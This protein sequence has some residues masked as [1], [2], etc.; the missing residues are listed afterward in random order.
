MPKF[1]PHLERPSALAASPSGRAFVLGGAREGR[2]GSS[3]HLLPLP[4][5][6]PPGL[7]AVEGATTAA[8][9]LGAELIVI[10]T[11][12]GKILGFEASGEALRRLFELPAHQ[13]PV[14]ALVADVLGKTLVSV[15][16]DGALKTWSSTGTELKASGTAAISERPLRAVALDPSG[17]SL[18]AGGDDGVLRLL[19]IAEL[20]KA[21]RATP[22][23]GGAISALAFLGDGRVAA[24][25]ADGAIRFAF[26]EGQS[27]V[28]DRA[29]EHAHI[30][31][32]R[33]LV[34][35]PVIFGDADQELPRKLFS[36]GEDG[37]LKAWPIENR[38]RPKALELG[39]GALTALTHVPAKERAKPEDRGGQLIA[40]G[41]GRW[42]ALSAL[43]SDGELT[44][45][46]EKIGS[47]LDRL[48]EALDHQ[49]PAP[50]Q[51]AI[52]ALGA[53][54]EDAAREL[55]E[56]PLA[57]D[58]KPE[59]KVLAAKLLGQGA[60]RRAR[61]ALR[62]A[63]SDAHPDVRRAAFDALGTIEAD[64][65]LA[66][67]RAGLASSAE[68]LRLLAVERLPALRQRSPLVPGLIAERLSDG[69]A[70][71]R[72]K[73]LDALFGLEP[74]GALE[75]VR[76]TMKRGAPDVRAEA[77]IRLGTS[78][79]AEAGEARLI[80]E[81]ALDDADPA[82]RGMA[83]LI[84][85]G[86]VPRLKD[87]LS[88]VDPLTKDAL[89]KLQ[90][91][92]PLSRTPASGPLQEADK[93]TL[94]AAMASQRPDTALRGARCLALLGD[95][96]ST[97]ALLQ[98]SREPSAEI[99]RYVVEALLSTLRATP[100]D[101]RA[102]ARLEWLLDDAEAVVRSAAFDALK[103]LAAA[104]AEPA[105]S[106]LDLA[107]IALRSAFEDV[108]VRALQILVAVGADSPARKRADRLV[109]DALDDEA[110]KVRNEAFKTLWA[111]HARQPK[112]ALELGARS[113][114]ADVRR[115]VISELERQKGDFV[116]PLL[117]ELVQD[118]VSEVGL[119]AYD[120]LTKADA[121]K[122]RGDVHLR[123]MGSPRFEVRAKGAA[124]AAFAPADEMKSRL[125]QL[126]EDDHP[127]VHLAAIE[128]LDKLAGYDEVAFAFAF[129][130]V[131]YEL[132]VR[133][134]ELAGTRRDKRCVDPLKSF[135][136]IPKTHVSRP[137]EDLRA[138]AA[139]AL[140]DVGDP[141]IV[142]FYVS[143]LDDENPLV[144]EMGARGLATACR[145]GAEGPLIAALGH[146]ELPVRSWAA[147]GLA[148][149]GDP[150]ALPVLAGTIRHEHR[151]IRAGAVLGF[152]ALGA[153]GVQ[154]ILQALSDPDR[155]VQDLV[156]AVI[157]AR[158]V[159]LA[160]A[161]L[162]PDLLVSAL[163]SSHP[164]VRFGAA[165]ALEARAAKEP[166]ERWALGLVG[167][168]RPERADEMKS[169]PPEAKQAALL[170]VLVS[171]LASDDPEQR[172][173]A[174]QVLSL[175]PQPEAFWREAQRLEKPTAAGR[176]W[177]PH[178]NFAA[179]KRETRKKDWIRRLFG[180]GEA[181]KAASASADTARV[182]T[183][184][185]LTGGRGGGAVPPLTGGAP[186][187]ELVFGAYA[188]LVRQAPPKGDADET[189][190]VR[191][192]ALERLTVLA[193]MPAIGRDA[194]LPIARR[195]LS[196]PHY[197]V[198]RSA[199]T[200]LRTLITD[201]PLTPEV[202]ALASDAADVGQKAVDALVALAQAGN[203]EA[204]A[205]VIGALS[206]R[207][208]DVRS[209]ALQRLVRLFPTGS[210]EPWLIALG[211]PEPDVRQAV[212]DRVL[213]A[214]DPRIFEA[215][216]RALESDDADLR[217]KAAIALA[218]RGDVRTADVLAGFLRTDKLQDA[219][220]ALVSLSAAE[221]K[222]SGRP[223]QPWEGSAR[224]ARAVAERLSNDP[225]RS[226]PRRT[227]I[228]ALATIGDPAGDRVLLDF[229]SAAPED[230]PDARY[231]ALMALFAIARHK[232]EPERRLKDGSTRP[233]YEEAQL[234]S[235]VEEAVRS[236][237]TGLRLECAKVLGSVADGGAERALAALAADRDPTVRVAAAE[238]LAFRA[239][240]FEAATLD[241]LAALL[242]Q[243]RR[244]LVLP[245]AEGLAA[246]RRPEAFQ[247]LLLV[248]K[249]GEPPERLRAALALGSLGDRRAI[250]HLIGYVEP[251]EELEEAELPLVPAAAE[252]LGRM[253]ARLS[254]EEE[255]RVRTLV[256][257]LA[258]E[259]GPTVNLP[260]I[261]G[262]R[263]AGDD[264]S[265][266][267]VE[268]IAADRVEQSAV[269][270]YAA[271]ELGRFPKPATSEG[272]LAGL[273]KDEDKNVRAAALEA[274]L[275]AFPAE[276]T[277]VELHALSSPYVDVS[278]TA[279][280]FLATRGDPV[281]L[282]GRLAEIRDPEV[283]R[284][285]RHGLVRRK[286]APS[287]ELKNLFEAKLAGVR[288][289]AAHLA[290]A[291]R[292][293][294]LGPTVL[295]ALSK[296]RGIYAERSARTLPGSRTSEHQELA[297]VAQ[298]WSLELWAAGQLG[299]DAKAETLP[300]VDARKAPAAVRQAA[301]YLLAETPEAVDL[302]ALRAALGDSSPLVRRAAGAVLAKLPAAKSAE[303]LRSEQSPDPSAIRRAVLSLDPATAAGFSAT[304]G[305]FPAVLS[306]L[307]GGQ[308]AAALLAIA[309]D[310]KLEASPERLAAIAALGL[311]GGEEVKAALLALYNGAG[312]DAVKRAAFRALR[313]LARAA[314]PRFK[315]GED[316]ERGK[317]GASSGGGGDEDED[318]GDE[319]DDDGGDDDEDEDEDDDE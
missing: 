98:L 126:V 68:D 240:N 99:R 75:P 239:E 230:A 204:K 220:D 96:R 34:M 134:G 120:K 285:L 77:L 9:F 206:A 33:A 123:A 101:D 308:R 313:R 132:R 107:E 253:L 30:G 13:G 118:A 67:A 97:G 241:P 138:R 245:A 170:Q 129:S 284:R 110:P 171:A 290:G 228:E 234:L 162:P 211:S 57:R 61:A 218:R 256:V 310:Q 266:T 272:V 115:G 164:E 297:D 130:S 198:R 64:D 161:G 24:G 127:S 274:L 231:P 232:S 294:A 141:A 117:L 283:R 108:R 29:G 16:A 91:R 279:A 41:R 205:R 201:D 215:L 226:A 52:E 208:A 287:A 219:L 43:S 221:A 144:R 153:D 31:P 59:L 90:T 267:V 159:A 295:A 122:K 224:A 249:A 238:S 255:K 54:T 80:V 260:A 11:D 56:L 185:R 114:H 214:E 248:L 111:W 92:G 309:N 149:L 156:F 207:S 263:H 244:E 163:S 282:A 178:T 157:V 213:D 4:K 46:F 318:D 286:A 165:R 301:L 32:I 152:V 183:V 189:H 292:D 116:R 81:A 47:E 222:K 147:E 186:L 26:T 106:D 143:L 168:R 160:K 193:S 42:L 137:S 142:P 136:S 76:L 269:R 216:G 195:A 48:R 289:D 176:P 22:L 88:K 121:D 268:N 5:L 145:L 17:A 250:E 200:A 71:V 262:L 312:P 94:F 188:G 300:L 50:R 317:S 38:R 2:P 247:A 1:A 44:D 131:F 223:F 257:R 319:D 40:S 166:A 273:L 39:L 179:E 60:R 173:T 277:R 25:S 133:A 20:S 225:D 199:V 84:G 175:R 275:R 306:G 258:T 82:V 235:Y 3:I 105:T 85:V 237:D 112:T 311:I 264:Q 298:A 139:R 104:A 15:G 109:G 93:E 243:G 102:R 242:R 303:I 18:A 74:A 316:Q 100:S 184:I 72:V 23:E 181:T 89:D 251:T 192:D 128:A 202:L 246:R 148:R 291:A 271:R 314:T 51:A 172:Y 197:L 236:T 37:I 58:K 124:G 288:L 304:K 212:V 167:P 307:L 252:A 158:D 194:V 293:K 174:A 196:D 35:G 53:I 27:D 36:A 103:A 78:G 65:P 190:R 86:S 182:L 180:R 63:L 10:G 296:E 259:G 270:A 70:A 315:E 191:R 62:A 87:A 113:R 28:E 95:A 177:I 79:A 155:D 125:R 21:P 6:T 229:I 154:G 187:G 19:A 276:R 119:F 278:Q 146:A 302:K 8:T 261:T 55:L 69:A 7:G 217:K 281:V 169:W 12:Q 151:P 45:S 150:R 210:V 233:R 66:T 265:R 83:F 227:L 135:L 254:G 209:Y 203:A 73:A 140:A 280:S 299:V 14:T 305:A 49:N